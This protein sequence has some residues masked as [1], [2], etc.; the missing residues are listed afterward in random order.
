VVR[1]IRPVLANVTAG[2]RGRDPGQRERGEAAER[3]DALHR[4][5]LRHE[6]LRGVG[7]PGKCT[8]RAEG[9]GRCVDA[10]ELDF[11]SRMKTL[12]AVARP[13]VPR[14]SRA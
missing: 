9:I 12:S 5:I 10:I 3:C 6:G 11:A 13:V 2:N 14:Q 1:V 4:W 7:A 8:A